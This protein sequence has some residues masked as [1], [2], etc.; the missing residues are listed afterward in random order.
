MEQK[1][2]EV[3]TRRAD[4]SLNIPKKKL[5]ASEKQ[6][7]DAI[8]KKVKAKLVVQEYEEARLGIIE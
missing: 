8:F 4:V 5:K 6:H 7:L 1:K 3:Q 2:V